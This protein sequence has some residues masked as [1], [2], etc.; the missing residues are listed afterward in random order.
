MILRLV[1]NG[2]R[3]LIFCG[4]NDQVFNGSVYQNYGGFGLFSASPLPIS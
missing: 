4:E 3:T 1:V 2:P